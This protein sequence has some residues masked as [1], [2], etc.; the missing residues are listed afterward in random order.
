MKE[1]NAVNKYFLKYK[2]LLLLGIIFVITSNIFGL[3]TP[4][5]IR[6]TVDI[7]KENLTAYHLTDGYVA[8]NDFKK[9]FQYYIIFFALVILITSLIK[10]LLMFFMIRLW[11]FY[12]MCFMQLFIFI[13]RL[14]NN[15]TIHMYF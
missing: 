5:Y 12:L 6:Y 8:Q 15:R 2:W 14:I 11:N 4:E 1:L 9:Q 3:Y 13:D 7:V 10:G